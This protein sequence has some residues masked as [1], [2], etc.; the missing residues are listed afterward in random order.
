MI[1]FK[2]TVANFWCEVKINCSIGA[3]QSYA[4]LSPIEITLNHMSEVVQWKTWALFAVFGMY[5]RVIPVTWLKPL[6]ENGTSTIEDFSV[7]FI[8][9]I[10]CVHRK[11][12][13]IFSS[14]LYILHFSAG[15]IGL[16]QSAV[17][18][19]QLIR[20]G[21]WINF[22]EVN[23]CSVCVWLLVEGI[24]SIKIVTEYPDLF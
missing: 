3:R 4:C 21:I 19:D 2:Q 23:V 6:H 16:S 5:N 1:Y 10:P 24:N 20:H 8:C 14:I 18:T 15:P 7:R 13:K 22:Q 12:W 17:S 9:K 11:W